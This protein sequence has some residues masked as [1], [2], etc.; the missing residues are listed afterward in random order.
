MF[1]ARMPF[2]EVIGQERALSSLR[3]ALRRGALHHA[4][5]FGGPEG[6]S[7]GLAARLLAQAANCEAP[8]G[9]GGRRDDHRHR[10]R[11]RRTRGCRRWR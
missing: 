9:P 7:K 6:A 10:S 11:G 3:S 2:S 8:A 4:Y 1:R 5:L